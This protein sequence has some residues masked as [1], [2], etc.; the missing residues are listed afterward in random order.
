MIYNNKKHLILL[1]FVVLFFTGGLYSQ[2]YDTIYGKITT[3]PCPPESMP[4]SH[5]LVYAIHYDNINYITTI[6]G[7]HA[8]LEYF[9]T[10]YEMNDSVKAVG[11]INIKQ[12]CQPED[13]Y[14]IELTSIE[15]LAPPPGNVTLDGVIIDDANPATTYPPLPGLVWQLLANGTYYVLT[16]NDYWFGFIGEGFDSIPVGG[17]FYNLFD[18]VT[19][20]GYIREHYDV[21]NEPY[22]TF[23]PIEMGYTG[24]SEQIVNKIDIS[25]NP[26]TGHIRINTSADIKRVD[27]YDMNGKQIC[28][29]TDVNSNF[30]T[31][32]NIKAKGVLFVRVTL[33]NNQFVVKKIV[34]I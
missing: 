8:G 34:V 25:P 15:K 14:E 1:V 4:S 9:G 12:D 26:S 30:A 2:N 17:N 10:T 21:F 11:T 32:D 7:E 13:Y 23:E 6:N 16:S 20:I 27:V 31:I 29:K 19:T 3:R 5:N 22:Y 33:K 24:L 18:R 28:S